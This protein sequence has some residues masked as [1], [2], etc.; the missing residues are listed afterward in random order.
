MIK[1]WTL[2]V[3]ISPNLSFPTP[4]P[5]LF[6]ERFRQKQW[7]NNWEKSCKRKDELYIVIR[8]WF[9]KLCGGGQLKWQ[10]KENIKMNLY[11]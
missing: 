3:Y 7:T 2:K 6:I 1:K 5:N 10:K 8:L 9:V 4:Y 11:T